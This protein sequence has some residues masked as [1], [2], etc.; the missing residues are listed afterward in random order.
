MNVINSTN[1]VYLQD[2][3]GVNLLD[4]T[5][6]EFVADFAGDKNLL[7]ESGREHSLDF[8]NL[9][10]SDKSF[11]SHV[12]IR[13]AGFAL[14]YDL[15]SI[16]KFDKIYL[17][18]F[19]GNYSI[20]QFE[21]YA[22]K[23]RECLFNSES[24]VAFVNNEIEYCRNNGFKCNSVFS[25]DIEAGEA[26]YIALKQISTNDTEGLSR[27]T[28]FGVYSAEYSF[29]K[30]YLKR[31]GLN[32]SLICGMLP[33]YPNEKELA[34]LT[35]GIVMD[36]SFSALLSGKVIYKLS[37]PQKTDRIILIGEK[38]PSVK[39]SFA[40]NEKE[41]FQKISQT[42]MQTAEL[43]RGRI[44]C[45]FEVL[46]PSSA[47]YF[48]LDFGDNTAC[49]DQICV[50]CKSYSVCVDTSEV[51]NNDFL[52]VGAN[53]LP[54]HLFPGTVNLGYDE[55]CFELEKC[56]LAKLKP[57]VLRVW[58]QPDWFIMDEQDFY[59]RRYV[60]N[61]HYM[62]A[63]YKEIEAYAAAGV[64]V[65]LNFGWKTSWAAQS[66]FSFPNVIKGCS[67]PRDLKQFAVACSDL[68][69]ELLVNRGYTHIKYLTFFNE[70]E[71]ARSEDG[72]DF[73]VP[74]Y[75]PL[76]YWKE[77]LRLCDEQ[78][79]KDGIRD[80]IEIWGA[81]N[82]GILSREYE[83]AVLSPWISEL[84]Q[85]DSSC[86]KISLHFYKCTADSARE[87][88]SVAQKY[89]NGKPICITEFGIFNPLK[90]HCFESNNISVALG[91]INGG[92]TAML[93]WYL[94]GC[95]LEE[96]FLFDGGIWHIPLDNCGGIEAVNREFYEL[97]LIT[98]YV[99]A[100][101]KV[102]KL[103]EPQKD[104]HAAAA[105]TPSGDITVLIE[106]K[107]DA[108]DKKIDVLFDQ[109]INKTFYKH[110][111]TLET[112]TNG[113]A[114]VPSACKKIYVENRLTD[115]IDAQ[116]TFAVYT[117]VKPVKQIAFDSMSVTVK[118]GESCRLGA[119]I[120][121]GDGTEK[122][123]WSICDCHYSFPD[124]GSITEDGVYT[125]P[126]GIRHGKKRIAV[127]AEISSGEY[128]VCLIYITP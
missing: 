19:E 66:W 68:L 21:I 28:C 123:K 111:Y 109:K 71:S 118:S 127:K 96:L 8:L 121:D 115:V 72:Y 74:D 79:K 116:Y 43:E 114:I 24:R 110:I 45:E 55:A 90:L 36:N 97:S 9:I 27:I 64:L 2:E 22:S 56:R 89:S 40:N 69:K 76:P 104:I 57:T 99:P 103:K 17:N 113:N 102:L 105:V 92:A 38:I 44:K 107:K 15:G 46:N 53:A 41:L 124:I 30:C 16:R 58:F 65:E 128:G 126:A 88:V 125:A 119:K 47:E 13:S 63:F 59:N 82:S 94:S 34:A 26:K 7:V 51:L 91:L 20:G 37:Y 14:I 61:S 3:L 62:R 32:E 85:G 12:D 25:F 1:T 86:D 87:S 77:M 35:D 106:S 120:I 67:A 29:S 49:L 52:G 73:G 4:G 48:A 42:N 50:Y 100:H 23:E 108:F 112:Q 95:Y 98:N 84:S 75:Q 117:T 31:H 39:I 5:A 18:S 6:P 54:M 80:L 33:F 101:S 81:E 78:L 70:P 10:T 93:F 122:I 60:F 11:S 83:C